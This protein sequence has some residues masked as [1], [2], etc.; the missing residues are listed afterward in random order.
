MPHRWKC[1]L[2]AAEDRNE[3]SL[4]HAILIKGNDWLLQLTRMSPLHIT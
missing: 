2:Y 1:G 4:M 3:C